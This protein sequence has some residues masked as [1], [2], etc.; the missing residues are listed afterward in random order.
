MGLC[1]WAELE[2]FGTSGWDYLWPRLDS[3]L[4]EIIVCDKIKSENNQK[5]FNVFLNPQLSLRQNAVLS[6]HFLLH[7][8]NTNIFL[9]LTQPTC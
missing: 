9:F 2:Y 1:I 5:T 3:R 7:M 6:V 4:D 8:C